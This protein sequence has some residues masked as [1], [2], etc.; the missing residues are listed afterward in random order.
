MKLIISI[1]TIILFTTLS[2]AHDGPKQKQDSTQQVVDSLQSQEHQETVQTDHNLA[3]V[4]EGHHAHHEKKV[5]ADLADFP[6]I[7]PLIVHFAIVLLIVGAI[8]AVVNIYFIKKE[9]AWTAFALVLVGFVAAYLA[10]RNFHPH[11]HGLTEHAKL[12]LEQHDFWADWTINLGFIGLLLQGINL[13]IFQSKR[14]AMAIVAVV[15]LSAAYAVAQA[16]HYGA[17][18]V[19]IEGVGPQGNFL[20]LEHDH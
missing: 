15:L 18:L 12:V 11:T 4:E 2:F 9:L 1:I 16:G 14:W 3:A 8:L 19:H 20:E 6:T 13:F 7:H 5:T 10:G 17:Q